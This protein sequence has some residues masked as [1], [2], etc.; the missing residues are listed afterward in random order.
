MSSKKTTNQ[1]QLAIFCL[2]IGAFAG[3]VIW[4]F[5]KI[6]SVGMEFIWQWGPEHIEIPRLT[7]ILPPREYS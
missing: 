6:M 5:L 2:L 3:A 1:I 7:L 4:V